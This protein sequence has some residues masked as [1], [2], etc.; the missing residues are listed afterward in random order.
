MP[1][2]WPGPSAQVTITCLGQGAVSSHPAAPS[3]LD[4]GVQAGLRANV[5]T[6]ENGSEGGRQET[7]TVCPGFDHSLFCDNVNHP[8]W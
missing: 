1:G 6:S 4:P 5:V 7:S 2:A 3:G 8:W